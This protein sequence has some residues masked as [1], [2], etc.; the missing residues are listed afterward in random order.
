MKKNVKNAFFVD[1]I[2][3]FAKNVL[4]LCTQTEYYKNKQLQL[5][6]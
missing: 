1:F 2:T 3:N 5:K 6:N 4:F